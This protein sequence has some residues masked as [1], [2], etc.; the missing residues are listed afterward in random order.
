MSSRF[1][2]PLTTGN[3]DRKNSSISEIAPLLFTI[4]TGRDEA[5]LNSMQPSGLMDEQA[6]KIP[7]ISF[8]LKPRMATS[9]RFGA[10]ES[11]L[12]S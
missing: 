11:L 8:G 3:H 12:P 4:S 1:S 10:L 2:A 7:N 5:R 9:T 6:Q